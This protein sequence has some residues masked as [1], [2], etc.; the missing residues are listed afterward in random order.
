MRAK[1]VT[2]TELV[3]MNLIQDVH[4]TVDHLRIR[5]LRGWGFSPK[6]VDDQLAIL[7][8]EILENIHVTLGITEN[9]K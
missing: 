8:Q 3:K 6:G 1:R 2:I 7:A 9:S 5:H 4:G